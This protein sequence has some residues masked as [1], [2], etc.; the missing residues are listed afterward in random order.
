M[1]V[2][3]E[4]DILQIDKKKKRIKNK[5]TNKHKEKSKLKRH[6]LKANAPTPNSIALLLEFPEIYHYIIQNKNQNNHISQEVSL[7]IPPLA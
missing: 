5:K 6:E 2:L 4:N 3:F 1:N 7:Y